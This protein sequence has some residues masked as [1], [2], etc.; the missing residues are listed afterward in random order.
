MREDIRFSKRAA[1]LTHDSARGKVKRNAGNFTRGSQLFHHQILMIWAGVRIPVY[2]WVGT[3]FCLLTILTLITFRTHEVNLVLMRLLAGFWNW[4]ALN[5]MKPVNLTL[6][7]GE[8]V[9]GKMVMVPH[10]PA[11]GAAWAKAIQVSVSAMVGSVFI[12]VPLT[13]W[14]FDFSRRRGS[15]ILTERHER[16]AVKVERDVLANAIVEYNWHEHQRECLA[17]HP[18]EDPKGVLKEDIRSR[19]RRGLHH[20]Y[21]LAGIPFP[22][23]LEQSHAMFIGTTGAGK[24]TELKKIVTQARARGQRCQPGHDRSR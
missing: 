10:H 15:E 18:A 9:Q 11:V 23:R 4:M 13:V 3:T 1:T 16:G 6:P 14:F 20:P 12:C 19:T 7:S 2:T 22:W 8:L 5:P 21:R 24:T 17:C